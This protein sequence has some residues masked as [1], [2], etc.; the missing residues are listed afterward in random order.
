MK[1]FLNKN[2]DLKLI[3]KRLNKIIC[4]NKLIKIYP[5]IKYIQSNLVNDSSLLF[6]AYN[7]VG[8]RST[9]I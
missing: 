9:F 4:V 5:N 1:N 6:N 2:W 8:G 3:L 7:L